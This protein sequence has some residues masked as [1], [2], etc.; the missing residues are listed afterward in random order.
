MSEKEMLE[1]VSNDDVPMVMTVQEEVRPTARRE[2]LTE[3][4]PPLLLFKEKSERIRRS[5]H[6]TQGGKCQNV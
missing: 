5:E 1:V 4:P 3:M 2:K 6:P